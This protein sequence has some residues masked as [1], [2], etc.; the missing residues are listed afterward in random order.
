MGGR[1]SEKNLTNEIV[2]SAFGAVIVKYNS[3]IIINRTV[4]GSPNMIW[5]KNGND[6]NRAVH[7]DY[8]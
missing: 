2:S 8:L 5:W 4:F 3:C 1:I 7:R 6:K